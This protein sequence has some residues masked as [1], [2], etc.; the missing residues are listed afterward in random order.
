MICDMTK[1]ILKIIA[2]LAAGSS[3]AMMAAIS[4][5]KWRP[6]DHKPENPNYF[7]MTL[8]RSFDGL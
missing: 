2:F 3:V 1:I 7:F 8:T 6:N 4:N 5:S